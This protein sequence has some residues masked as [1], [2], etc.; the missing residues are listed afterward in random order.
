MLRVRQLHT[1]KPQSNATTW[2]LID[3]IRFRHSCASG[4]SVLTFYSIYVGSE[5][6]CVS[7]HQTG[8]RIKEEWLG[9][10]KRKIKTGTFSD[11]FRS[12]LPLIFHLQ[13]SSGSAYR[14]GRKR[15][16]DRSHPNLRDASGPYVGEMTSIFA[17]AF[18]NWSCEIHDDVNGS[19]ACNAS[20]AQTS[21]RCNETGVLLCELS[22]SLWKALLFLD[23]VQAPHRSKACG[24][25]YQVIVTWSI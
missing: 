1:M 19:A 16:I 22:V 21:S 25:P 5:I 12:I 3:S 7:I 18:S 24:L 10:N 15:C 8:N 20:Y 6:G 4:S 17:P 11:L 23:L 2:Y 13:R 9:S 14:Q